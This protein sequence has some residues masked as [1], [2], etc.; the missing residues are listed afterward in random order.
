MPRLARL[1]IRGAVA[2]IS[3]ALATPALAHPG[4]GEGGGFVAGL[5]HPLTGVDHL[6]AM[7]MVGLW[8]GIAFQRHWWLCPAAFLGFMVTGFIWGANGA[9][10]PIAE[11]LIIASLAGIGLALVFNLRPP[12]A[13]GAAVVAFFAIGHGY[14]HGAEIPAGG[15]ALRFMAGFVTTT[16]ALHFAGYRLSRCT[17]VLDGRLAG[18]LIGLVAT[19]TA[20]AMLWQV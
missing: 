7:V 11:P 20:A 2:A 1:A 13:L 14:A 3:V 10:L 19:G 6:L 9:N 15:N 16:A 17:G 12:L 4:H 18:R 5:L 8:A